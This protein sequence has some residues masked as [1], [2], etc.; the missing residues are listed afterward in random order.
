MKKFA[1]ILTA[2]V[3]CLG[4]ASPAMAQIAPQKQ[5]VLLTSLGQAADVHTVSVLAKRAGLPVEYETFASA[6]NLEGK[7][8]MLV[9]VGVSL[10]G[11]GSAGVNLESETARANELF[12]YAKANGIY[13]IVVHI[14]G[15]ERRDNMSNLMLDVAIPLA[16]AVIVYAQ[17]N[18]DG[19]FESKAN[20][21]PVVIL[22]KTMD[23]VAT[24]KAIFPAE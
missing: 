15:E 1:K 17:A 11:F 21:K 3:L 19:Y 16:D 18:G 20:G 14:G 8:T 22:N 7:Q 6:A 10:K 5:P 4:L 9:V 23:M 12:S 13:T 2:L 24:L